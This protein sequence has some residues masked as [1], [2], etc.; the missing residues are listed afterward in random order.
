MRHL[1]LACAVLPILAACQPTEPD[2]RGVRPGETLLTISATGRAD[3]RPDE[4][5]HGLG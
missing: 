5:R 1:A 2:P 3:S 4:A